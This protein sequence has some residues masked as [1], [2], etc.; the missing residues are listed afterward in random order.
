[1]DLGPIVILR[2]VFKGVAGLVRGQSRGLVAHGAGAGHQLDGYGH[3]RGPGGAAVGI[4]PDLFNRYIYR[5]RR[6]G[7]GDGAAI[8]SRAAGSGV[9]RDRTFFHRI[10]GFF[11]VNV[12]GESAVR[13]GIGIIL[14]VRNGRV[15]LSVIIGERLAVRQQAEVLLILVS[16]GTDAVTVAIVLPFLGDCDLS[17]LILVRIV[18]VELA[19][20]D[21]DR[22]RGSQVFE[23][24]DCRCALI[25][26]RL[27]LIPALAANEGEAIRQINLLDLVGRTGRQ[28]DET[29]GPARFDFYG[30]R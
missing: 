17:L 16:A 15:R 7:I 12:L 10:Y 29:Q 18:N 20:G 23:R 9:V 24:G 28:V 2:Q 8:G 30:D 27:L 11:I 6:M 26:I 14:V 13:N 5:F 19:V 25:K 21:I 1:M 22:T 4:R 3:A